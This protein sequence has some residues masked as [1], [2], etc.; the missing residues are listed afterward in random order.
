MNNTAL[1]LCLS[2]AITAGLATQSMAAGDKRPGMSFEEVDTNADGLMTREELLAHREARFAT[3]D[4]DGNGALTRAELEARAEG[5]QSERRA[6]F[7]DRMFE[8][9]DANSD[10]ELSLEEM[11]SGKTDKMFERADADGDGLISK[12]EFDAA[13]AARG[14]KKAD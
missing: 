7:L 11:A 12:A 13:R 14:S 9:R 5:A 2:V 10:G 1:M 3:A 4:T 6:K 8:R